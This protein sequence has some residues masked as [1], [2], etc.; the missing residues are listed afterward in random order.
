MKP[1]LRKTGNKLAVKMGEETIVDMTG[2]LPRKG[3][4][5]NSV[6]QG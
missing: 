1:K 3:N 5:K 6:I 2:H 4:C